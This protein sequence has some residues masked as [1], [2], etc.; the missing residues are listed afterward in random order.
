M[1]VNAASVMWVVNILTV[2]V[3][4]GLFFFGWFGDDLDPLAE[5]DADVC[6]VPVEHLHRQHEVLAFV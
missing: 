5:E 2:C 1:V 6:A 4:E 3:F